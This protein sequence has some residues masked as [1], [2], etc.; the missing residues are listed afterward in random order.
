[1]A[2]VVSECREGKRERTFLVAGSSTVE[3]RRW[4]SLRIAFAAMPVV[5]VLKSIWLVPRTR[6]LKE[7]ERGIKDEDML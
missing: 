6:A 2:W 1:M 7:S 5:A 4:I 3:M